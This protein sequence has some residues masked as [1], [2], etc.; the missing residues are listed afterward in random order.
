MPT[1]CARASGLSIEIVLQITDD[2]LDHLGNDKG[3]DARKGDDLPITRPA[4][5]ADN[6]DRASGSRKTS[7]MGPFEQD[8]GEVGCGLE[9]F[10]EASRCW[11]G[12]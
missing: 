7:L 1:C 3:S 4:L 8:G 11:P 9:A 2:P 10:H 12:G 6:D 5:V